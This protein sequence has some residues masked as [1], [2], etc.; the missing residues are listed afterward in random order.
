MKEH[1]NS[2]SV[3]LY[4]RAYFF[5]DCLHTEARCKY[6]YRQGITHNLEKKLWGPL[7]DAK[8]AGK[9]ALGSLK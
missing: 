5:D 9:R 7:H 1:K 8:T 6:M 4:C 3:L 2:L